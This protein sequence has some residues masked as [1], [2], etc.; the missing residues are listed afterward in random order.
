MRNYVLRL[1]ILVPAAAASG[2]ILSGC[3]VS[4]EDT[5]LDWECSGTCEAI[6][7]DSGCALERT[8]KS[9]EELLAFCEEQCNAAKSVEVDTGGMGDYDPWEYYPQDEELPVLENSAQA[10]AWAECVDYYSS[11]GCEYLDAGYCE[12]IW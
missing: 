1:V 5:G 11:L 4:S 9:Q 7:G 2:P 12:P 10:D 6:Y 8:G 3:G